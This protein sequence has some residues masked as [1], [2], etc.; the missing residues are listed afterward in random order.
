MVDK[1]RHDEGEKWRGVRDVGESDV[2]MRQQ[3]TI[4]AK[5]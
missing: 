1:E 2:L 3:A 5:K 4:D